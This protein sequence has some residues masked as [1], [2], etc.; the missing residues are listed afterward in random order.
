[1]V[2][3]AEE[4]LSLDGLLLVME[5][6]VRN[7]TKPAVHFLR[8]LL[9]GLPDSQTIRCTLNRM[10]LK[11]HLELQCGDKY[12][13]P[14]HF[15]S[16]NAL[17]LTGSA[18]Q[19]G[20]TFACEALIV[21]EGLVLTGVTGLSVNVT[22]LKGEFRCQVHQV[23]IQSSGGRCVMRLRVRNP[24]TGRADDADSDVELEADLTPGAVTEDVRSEVVQLERQAKARKLRTTYT[25]MVALENPAIDSLARKTPLVRS[26]LFS[27]GPSSVLER[28]KNLESVNK[29]V[30]AYAIFLFCVAGYLATFTAVPYVVPITIVLAAMSA[31]LV[32]FEGSWNRKSTIAIL[33]STVAIFVL[34]VKLSEFTRM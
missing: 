16:R 27:S 30:A 26:V 15:R 2:S 28:V 22:V 12:T 14:L 32:G 11:A 10:L 6:L 18:L 8:R 20:R 13:E 25:N 21:D 7:D 3:G 17:H 29:L 33:L 24:L 9:E 23:H 5:T 19:I 4:S 31:F 34:I 1:M